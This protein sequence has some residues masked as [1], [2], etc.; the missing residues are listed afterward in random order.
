MDKQFNQTER[1]RT[2]FIGIHLAGSNSLKTAV[3]ILEQ[4]VRTPSLRIKK[5][6]EKIG[7]LGSSYS[8]DRI[9]KII[10]SES[11]IASIF[12]DTPLSYPPCVSC[13]RPVC[14]GVYA[15]EDTTVAY[16]LAL[17]QVNP[18][19]KKKKR[20]RPVNPQCHRL[21]D[22]FSASN[23]HGSIKEPSFSSNLAPLVIRG[24]T[25]QKR[26]RALN[27]DCTLK[28]TSV[29]ESLKKLSHFLEAEPDVIEKYRSFEVGKSVREELCL[30]F[31]RKLNIKSSDNGS[32]IESEQFSEIAHSLPVFSA[33]VT[34]CMAWFFV[35]KQL[36]EMPVGYLDT[37]GWVYTPN[38]D[39]F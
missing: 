33:F 14:P 3:I 21:W 30:A 24:Q 18:F 5:L 26:L 32:L 31:C 12:V 7:S 1:D 8:D 10:A 39:F 19:F 35:Q 25:L 22:I 16:M 6:Y 29:L 28:E 23:E 37:S 11:N 34:A 9:A 2:K 36:S 15:C 27:I 20:Q 4:Q 38:A 13:Q 17:A